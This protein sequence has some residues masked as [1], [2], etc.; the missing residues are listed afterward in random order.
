MQGFQSGGNP[1]QSG[2]NPEDILNELFGS[3]NPFFRGQ[4]R[5]QGADMQARISCAPPPH[6][7]LCVVVLADRPNLQGEQLCSSDT[8][9]S[10]EPPLC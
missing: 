10:A 9:A 1:F 4:Q 5:N 8:T 2:Q 6:L 3:G 7:T